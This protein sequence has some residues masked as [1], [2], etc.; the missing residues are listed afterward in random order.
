[1]DSGADLLM[2]GMGEHSV[3][4]IAEA[5]D[6]GLPVKE[7][8]YVR[9]GFHCQDLSGPGRDYSPAFLAYEEIRASKKTFAKSFYTQYKNT[10]A[11]TAGGW[12]SPI[13]R[14]NMWC[15]ILRPSP[16]RG[17]DGSHL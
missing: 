11:I 2:Y 17:G 15:R 6:A 13:K 14:K 5:L 3:L 9:D 1:M 10:D 7:I 16:Y 8:S 4:E 12:W